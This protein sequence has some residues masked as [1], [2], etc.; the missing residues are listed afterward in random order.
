M[1]NYISILDKGV[2]NLGSILSKNSK[3]DG[4]I[5]AFFFLITYFSMIYISSLVMPYDQFW[6]YLGVPSM[7]PS[8]ADLRNITSALE[9][10]RQGFDPL[11]NNPCDPWNR[12]MN[13]P[14]I[15][16]G[17]S[18]LGLDQSHTFILG[19]FLAVLFY[20][21]I[22]FIV[23]TK[24][25]NVSEGL[26]YGLVLC[27]PAVMLAVERGNNDMV[28]F[29]F[30]GLCV[31]LI[32]KQRI[33]PYFLILIASILKLYPILGIFIAIRENKRLFIIITSIMSTILFIY[34]MYIYKDIAL[35]NT[36]MPKSAH[37][38]YGSRVIFDGLN[39]FFQKIPIIGSDGIP[40]IFRKT[41]SFIGIL[42]VLVSAYWWAYKNRGL[43]VLNTEQIDSFR[44]GAIIYIGTFIIIGNNWD[45]RLIFL[46]LTLPQL[47]AGIK[48]QNE[49]S[50]YAV[51]LLIAIL[52]T[53]YS[54]LISK[55]IGG[56][57]V[58][59]LEELINWLIFACFI[60]VLLLTL[61]DWLKTKLR[62]KNFQID[63]G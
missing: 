63:Y 48:N 49:L 8:F 34:F 17:L 44:M 33:L 47:F 28:I 39:V 20:A 53:M 38:S 46:I 31:F 13:Y 30:L 59:P 55:M 61:P 41:F 52:F 7:S 25:L 21:C 36:F 35:I 14:R 5:I 22:F 10:D 54:S 32:Q 56:Y 51:F 62:L 6:A 42:I 9:C 50:D 29:I 26:I 16:L 24:R 60:Y 1:N 4:R 2:R 12:P 15:W 11:I 58:F 45:Y 57:F 27:S 3:I 23:I 18:S 40:E 19:L 43:S 37:I